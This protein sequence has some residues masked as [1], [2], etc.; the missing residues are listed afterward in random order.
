MQSTRQIG[1][2]QKGA[3][4][5]DMKAR[6]RGGEKGG[7]RRREPKEK[8]ANGNKGARGGEGAENRE[9]RRHTRDGG[10]F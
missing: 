10:L 9:R 7:T 5:G 2:R 8:S 4:E 3:L 6:R 1:G